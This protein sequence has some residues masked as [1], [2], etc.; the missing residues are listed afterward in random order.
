MQVDNLEEGTT[1]SNESKANPYFPYPRSAN[2]FVILVSF[3]SLLPTKTTPE[4][5]GDLGVEGGP[6][7][8]VV[9][10]LVAPTIASSFVTA[11]I[12]GDAD[13]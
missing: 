8:T 7:G 2:Y 4:A 1:H 12:A 5:Q 11:V 3:L 6:D 10:V 13:V 9:G